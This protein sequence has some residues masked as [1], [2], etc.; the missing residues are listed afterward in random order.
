M[1]AGSVTIWGN[2]VEG[3]AW[4]RWA[5]IRD[6]YVAEFA[7]ENVVCDGKLMDWGI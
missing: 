4:Y 3:R 2:G 7:G 6:D 5:A 1:I